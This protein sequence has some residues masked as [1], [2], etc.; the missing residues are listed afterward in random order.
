MTLRQ[1]NTRDI[2][3]TNESIAKAL[4]N[5]PS[6]GYDYINENTPKAVPTPSTFLTDYRYTYPSYISKEFNPNTNIG[7]YIQPVIQQA[8]AI[9]TT[10]MSGISNIMN[11]L[12][13]L[14][15]ASNLTWNDKL[16]RK[17]LTMQ[18]G[19]LMGAIPSTYGFATGLGQLGL[20]EAKAPYDM[21]K[22][23]ASGYTAIQSAFIHPN[24]LEEFKNWADKMNSSSGIINQEEEEEE[25]K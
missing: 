3:I 19:H 25:E 12:A 4:S 14:N 10:I 1:D 16:T 22:D 20:L 9:P 2:L 13:R 21:F 23:Y 8:S 11:Q 15:A 17:Y 24:L 6:E 5:I 18:L 7:S